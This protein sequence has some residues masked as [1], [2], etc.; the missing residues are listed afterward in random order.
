MLAG[1]CRRLMLISNRARNTIAP[2]RYGGSHH[3]IAGRRGDRGGAGQ[4]ASGPCR[5]RLCPA[6]RSAFRVAKNLGRFRVCRRVAFD[7]CR[8]EKYQWIHQSAEFRECSPETITV[9]DCRETANGLEPSNPLRYN[10]FDDD[11][12]SLPPSA[13]DGRSEPEG[14]RTGQRPDSKS[15]A[16]QGVVGSNPMPSAD[17]KK[18]NAR[19]CIRWR[20]QALVPFLAFYR[21]GVSETVT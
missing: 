8:G 4:A 15:G 13:A 18:T 19:A 21:W 9:A 1:S 20:M 16:P 10:E 11:R 6:C 7:L 2:G 17:V 12:R 5:F 3:R 14:K